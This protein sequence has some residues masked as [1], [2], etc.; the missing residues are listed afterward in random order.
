MKILPEGSGGFGGIYRG[1]R[2]AP[3][4][5]S[6]EYFCVDGLLFAIFNVTFFAV[7]L[8]STVR[9]VSFFDPQL[10]ASTMAR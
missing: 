9:S 6:P 10:T 3:A 4:G 7:N 1:S 5:F 8:F 2:P